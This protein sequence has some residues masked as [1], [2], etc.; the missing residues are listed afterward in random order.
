MLGQGS[1]QALYRLV[2]HQTDAHQARVLQTRGEKMDALAGAIDELHFAL[3]KIMLTELPRETFKTNQG[4]GRLR[5][6][7]GHQRLECSLASPI[8]RLARP[9]VELAP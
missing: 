3:S 9:V 8:A 1:H 6:Q 7:R 4:L 5:A 2:P